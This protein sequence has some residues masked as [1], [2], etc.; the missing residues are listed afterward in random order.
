MGDKRGGPHGPPLFSP[1]LSSPLLSGGRHPLEEAAED[2]R[3]VF[4]HCTPCWGAKVTSMP[5]GSKSSASLPYC[6]KL[7]AFW[8]L[9][10]LRTG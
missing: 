9:P 5:P 4:E 7:E 8:K 10:A 3:I 1:G 6:R 2:C